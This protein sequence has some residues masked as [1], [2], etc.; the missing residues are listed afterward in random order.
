[1]ERGGVAAGRRVGG[2]YTWYEHFAPAARLGK[3]C[4]VLLPVDDMLA[5]TR[6]ASRFDGRDLGLSSHPFDGSTSV[7][8]PAGLPVT[9][10]ANGIAVAVETS[11]GSEDPFVSDNGFAGTSVS[12][13]FR[14]GRGGRVTSPK[15]TTGW[16]CPFCWTARTGGPSGAAGSW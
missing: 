4:S 13:P 1:M 16:M 11:A 12:C 15:R 9:C 14:S 10:R 7:S 8:E 2:G 6:V 3:A 5:A